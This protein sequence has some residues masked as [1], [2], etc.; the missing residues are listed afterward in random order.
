MDQAV[1]GDDSFAT[2]SRSEIVIPMEFGPRQGMKRPGESIGDFV[3]RRRV[4]LK[5]YHE[6]TLIRKRVSYPSNEGTEGRWLHKEA[7]ESLRDYL[8]RSKVARQYRTEQEGEDYYGLSRTRS[9]SSRP[10]PEAPRQQQVLLR[11]GGAQDPEGDQPP[12]QQGGLRRHPNETAM[13]FL[14][15]C[16]D[17]KRAVKEAQAKAQER[18]SAHVTECDETTTCDS[19]ASADAYVAYSHQHRLLCEV[20]KETELVRSNLSNGPKR[21]ATLQEIIARRN[22]H[23]GSPALSPRDQKIETTIKDEIREARR[24]V[25]A[26]DEAQRA[27]EKIVTSNFDNYSQLD[28]SADSEDPSVFLVNAAPEMH[29]LRD[30]HEEETARVA[31]SK[32]VQR[33]EPVRPVP[34]IVRRKVPYKS[35]T[36]DM[37]IPEH[38]SLD[39]S[40]ESE[41][42]SVA[43]LLPSAEEMEMDRSPPSA[44]ERRT[45][46]SSSSLRQLDE[47]EWARAAEEPWGIIYP[48]TRNMGSSAEHLRAE[49]E[50]VTG[51]VEELQIEYLEERHPTDWKIR[52]AVVA[53]CFEPETL[54]DRPGIGLASESAMGLR[55]TKKT[56]TTVNEHGEMQ[57]GTAA[58]EVGGRIGRGFHRTD[59]KALTD[60]GVAGRK[61][62][63]PRVGS[64]RVR[65]FATQVPEQKS[66]G[67]ISALAR[68]PS[69]CEACQSVSHRVFQCARYI[70]A[71]IAAKK[72]IASQGGL[73]YN[74]LS[75]AHRCR[76]CTSTRRCKTCDG[77]HHTTLHQEALSRKPKLCLLQG[78]TLLQSRL[79]FLIV[80]CDSVP[81]GFVVVVCGVRM[82]LNVITKA[83]V[84]VSLGLLAILQVPAPKVGAKTRLCS[85]LNRAAQK[86]LSATGRHRRG[87]MKK[88]C[89][90]ANGKSSNERGNRVPTRYYQ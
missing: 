72:A 4:E 64:A 38:L 69:G 20:A 63:T 74:C 8:Q 80:C 81:S 47:Q 10:A 34:C 83:V 35:P 79:S 27:N 84:P 1:G 37:N 41:L 9:P 29:L 15:R 68:R 16:F 51:R 14:R 39:T 89:G 11:Q 90:G 57:T 78:K 65:S 58:Y 66:K 71:D 52:R 18:D 32:E 82:G 22:Q 86:G 13:G 75:P 87:K 3:T 59:E 53:K 55:F 7:H 46:D 88:V 40:E 48:L 12:K 19:P 70:A 49:T 24:L 62:A 42:S 28:L 61:Q 2:A 6:A 67:G 50:W 73:C 30:F 33:S 5:Q 56:L 77:K 85:Q 26:E 25:E 17:A 31:A 23:P 21:R 54:G 45:G 60:A 36:G 76:D 44:W 43:H